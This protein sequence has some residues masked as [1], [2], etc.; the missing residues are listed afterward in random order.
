MGATIPDSS[1]DGQAIHEWAYDFLLHSEL[2]AEVAKGLPE[3]QVWAKAHGSN[4]TLDEL[5]QRWIDFNGF[6]FPPPPITAPPW[7]DPARVTYH[8]A[9]DATA[10]IFFEGDVE[11][12]G[13]HSAVVNMT[14]QVSN[15]EVTSGTSL[16]LKGFSSDVA[17]EASEL[18]GFLEA[19]GELRRTLGDG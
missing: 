6:D 2:E 9:G 13:G 8:N 11:L 3:F 4:Y 7:A 16:L 5:A 19:V 15:G 18:G 1:V 14:I 17:L 10:D 12:G